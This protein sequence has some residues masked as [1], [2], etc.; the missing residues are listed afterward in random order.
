MRN[1]LAKS[2]YYSRAERIGFLVLIGTIF[3]GL[4]LPQCFSLFDNE[5]PF[6]NARYMAF[7]QEI[8][9]W[10]S[11]TAQREDAS[12]A[13]KT[14]E[15]T[16]L[17]AFDPN[18]ADKAALEALGFSPKQAQTVLNYRAK[19]GQFRA[20]EDLQKIYGLTIALYNKVA[21]Y[22]EI[23]GQKNTPPQYNAALPSTAVSLQAF[24]PNTASESLLLG[25]GLEDRT[26]KTLLKY[27]ASGG[28]FFKKEDVKKVYGF[29]EID[30]L[31][32]E[33]YIQIAENQSFENNAQTVQNYNAT[34]KVE[35]TTS[36]TTIDVNKA[37]IDEWLQLRGIGRT[38][39]T[40]ILEMREKLGGFTNLEQI[41]AVYGL[42]DSTYR[43]IF[44]QLKLSPPL[45]KL[46]VNIAGESELLHPYLSRKQAEVIVRYRINHGKFNNIEDLKKTGIF[47]PDNLEKLKPYIGF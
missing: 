3:L 16:A 18:T 9:V 14:V 35:Y 7:E 47:T 10:Q 2:F 45:R 37:S 27:R 22:I 31:R 44:P 40:R 30:Y 43:N 46:Q 5:K 6:D 15:N 13:N 12:E 8:A 17:F 41:R 21:P 20:A 34:K 26:V 25:L 42:P 1:F 24:D 23:G 38:F 11:A 28:R 39:A 19:G 29:S 32:L 36:E 4:C 33:K